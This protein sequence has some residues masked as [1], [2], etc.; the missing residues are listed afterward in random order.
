VCPPKRTVASITTIK[1]EF[2]KR[3]VASTG[4]EKAGLTD[5]EVKAIKKK[6]IYSGKNI[7]DKEYRKV[8]G[9]APLFMVN[10][11]A[12]RKSKEDEDTDIVV[13]TFGVSFPGDPGS[14]RRPEKLVQYRVNTVWW[15]KNYYMPDE[16]EEG[17]E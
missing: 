9:R 11:V 14:S 15:E 4:D 8:P 3:R 5:E 7:P 12:I 16:E 13:P 10:F 17:D 2:T 6:K 1:I